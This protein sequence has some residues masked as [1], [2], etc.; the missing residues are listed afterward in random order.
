MISW[1]KEGNKRS[2]VSKYNQGDWR[3]EYAN[4]GGG[5]HHCFWKGAS[6]PILWCWTNTQL[7]CHP[8]KYF[9]YS[10]FSCGF[11]AYL[12]TTIQTSKTDVKILKMRFSRFWQYLWQK[13]LSG[14]PRN[15]I[16]TIIPPGIYQPCTLPL[17][18]VFRTMIPIWVPRALEMVAWLK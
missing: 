6:F 3:Q 10:S 18:A 15:Q 12:V 5:V 14:G 16:E 9:S 1:Y 7:L 2:I 4:E 8:V 17:K 13:I 11:R